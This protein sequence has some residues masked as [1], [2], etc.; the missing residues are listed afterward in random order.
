MLLHLG[1][2]FPVLTHFGLINY[3]SDAFAR[4]T[5]RSPA[6]QFYG[7]NED[8]IARRASE[9]ILLAKC[10]RSKGWKY[11]DVDDKWIAPPQLISSDPKY[12]SRW[13]YGITTQIGFEKEFGAISGPPPSDPNRLVMELLS[14]QD[15]TEYLKD[16]GG[17][18]DNE[19]TGGCIAKA[20]KE[21]FAGTAYIDPAAQRQAAVLQS[22]VAS[23]PRTISALRDWAQCMGKSGFKLAIKTPDQPSE[24]FRLELQRLQKSQPVDSGKLKILQQLEQKAAVQDWFCRGKF[25][26]PV[27]DSVTA[28]KLKK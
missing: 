15:R 26:D 21:A 7:T 6:S 14:P 17:S 10:M 18:A 3:S 5:G 27:V 23:D 28:E 22:K 25:L 9:R 13:G 1:L 16:L 24:Y 12:A 11:V 8:L 20:R 4:E 2:F 19:I